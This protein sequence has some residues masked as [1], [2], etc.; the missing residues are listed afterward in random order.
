MNSN[1]GVAG[2][3]KIV[4]FLSRQIIQNKLSH[5]YLFLGQDKLGKRT[6]AIQF[7]KSIIC[8]NKSE[9]FPCGTCAPCLN[10]SKGSYND[11]FY[12]EKLSGKKGIV[13]EQVINLQKKL[14]LK[15]SKNNY[16]IVLIN[17][18]QYLTK[19]A[20]NRLL[21]ILEEPFPHTVFVL[22]G[23][24]YI[25]VLPTIRSR[26]QIIKFSPV[27][28]EGL[29]NFFKTNKLFQKNKDILKTLC[30]GKPGLLVD[31]L[32][33]VK[34]MKEQK[35]YLE[36]T[37]E[38]FTGKYLENSVFFQK[39]IGKGAYNIKI[40]KLKE[41]FSIISV[42]LRDLYLIKNEKTNSIILKFYLKELTEISR[43]FSLNKIINLQNKLLKL[44]SNFE[45]NPDL[46]ICVNSFL[47][48]FKSNN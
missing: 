46:N 41:L 10:F 37:L 36:N 12:L 22:T 33:D 39:K 34:E 25:N 21:K 3:D 24:S 42:C 29:D 40:D 1:W 26:C 20:A 27:S 32:D 7:A 43:A 11:F 15:S 18:A 47:Y 14:Y 17:K 8:A 48:E 2:H 13:L 4:R 9:N 23:D 31:F 5:A 45:Y 19:E 28:D 30:L 38:L 44:L 16:K 35:K 6:T